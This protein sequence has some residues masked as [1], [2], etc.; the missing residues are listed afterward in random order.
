MACEALPL[1]TTV[2]DVPVLSINACDELVLVEVILP[3]RLTVPIV[4]ASSSNPPPVFVGSEGL[5]VTFPVTCIG[6]VPE[7]FNNN[8]PPA[9]LSNVTL[10]QVMFDVVAEFNP[11]K[12]VDVLNLRL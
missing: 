4:P 3:A 5:I 9:E 10:L 12:F 8:F 1:N 6:V 11:Y 7:A 2:L